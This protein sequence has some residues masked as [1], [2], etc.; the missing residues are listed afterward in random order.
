MEYTTF[1]RTGLEVSR[2]CLGCGGLSYSDTWPWSACDREESLAVLERALD[3]GINFID[4]A[5][6]YS[7][8]ESEELVGE[9]IDGRR[10]DVV[11]ASKVGQSLGQD[12]N[13]D[14]L[15]KSHVIDQ[16]ERSLERLDTDYLDIYYAHWWDHDTD[17]RETLAAFDHLVS[18]GKVRYV[19]AC[20]LTGAQLERALAAADAQHTERYVAVQPEYS[21]L[22]RHEEVGLLPVADERDL[23]VATYAPLAAGFLTGEYDRDTPADAFETGSGETYRDLSKYATPANFDVV[24][25][26]TDIAAREGVHPV[27]VSVAWVL[28]QDV[29]DAPIVGPQT[30]EH[31]DTY[32][33][34]LEVSLSDADLERLEA[35][36]E[37][38]YTPGNLPPGG[39]WA[40]ERDEY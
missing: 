10:D 17:I 31:L 13:S 1:G 20:N 4:T 38:A 2:L 35:P 12:P 37:P 40:G 7:Y 5:N 16:A 24:D 30:T 27:A 19:G 32:L 36:V 18:E 25:A 21:L 29:V 22:R 8:G 23:G 26:V 3:A 9:A 11:L 39:D 34:A 15:S 6:V 14:G 33:E 28:H